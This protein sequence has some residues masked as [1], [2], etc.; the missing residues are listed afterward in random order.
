MWDRFKRSLWALHWFWVQFRGKIWSTQAA[1]NR[2]FNPVPIPEPV[3]TVP[4]YI[5]QVPLMNF[6]GS[7]FYQGG[8]YDDD[9]DFKYLEYKK[10]MSSGKNF[11]SKYPVRQH[12]GFFSRL[13]MYLTI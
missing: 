5:P 7:E 6:A 1:V 2:K 9:T 3:N 11:D 12:Q 13:S 10:F 4:Q 8:D